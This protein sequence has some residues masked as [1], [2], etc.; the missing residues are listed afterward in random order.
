MNFQLSPYLKFAIANTTT[1]KSE[2]TSLNIFCSDCNNLFNVM[3]ILNNMHS[4]LRDI[5]SEEDFAK[6]KWEMDI[7]TLEEIYSQIHASNISLRD[8]SLGELL[9]LTNFDYGSSIEDMLI[10]IPDDLGVR[11][12]RREHMSPDKL[13]PSIEAT[14]VK[15]QVRE[16]A[17]EL[18]IPLNNKGFYVNISRQNNL[19]NLVRDWR[20]SQSNQGR[21][22]PSYAQVNLNNNI[23]ELAIQKNKDIGIEKFCVM[24]DGY[25]VSP[26]DG[27]QLAEGVRIIHE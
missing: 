24:G 23:R 10:S 14:T 25:Y 5:H 15:E 4:F 9:Q 18:D 11:I 13:R 1:F 6:L 2:K 7:Q 3:L 22:N 21:W 8:I 16:L 27:W 17:E 20:A 12:M 19:S 26:L